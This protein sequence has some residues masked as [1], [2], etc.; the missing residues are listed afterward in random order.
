MHAT[1]IEPGHTWP[2]RPRRRV[3]IVVAAVAA[4]AFAFLAL[5]VAFEASWLRDI[6]TGIHDSLRRYGVEHPWWLATM[7]ALT[8]LGDGITVTIVDTTAFVVCLLR[9]RWQAAAFVASAGLGVWLVSRI[10]RAIVARDRPEDALWTADGHA[11]PSGHT[12]NATTMTVIVALLVW[13]LA[14]RAGRAWLVAGAVTLPVV[15]GFTRI[16]G[17]VHWPTDVL[18]SLLFSLAG[19]C[20]IA[21]LYPNSVTAGETGPSSVR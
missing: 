16:A 10:P 7:R 17:G 15:V 19:V 5:L 14:R 11:F 3:L 2:P 9:R 6:D 21:A 4:T 1:S 18:A 12:M 8:F 20:A 13:P